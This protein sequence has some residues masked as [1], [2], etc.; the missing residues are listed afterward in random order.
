M[1]TK[2]KQ[3]KHEPPKLAIVPPGGFP[4]PPRPSQAAVLVQRREAAKQAVKLIRE[5]QELLGKAGAT[6]RHALMLGREHK[7]PGVPIFPAED[8][9]G[10]PC[11][12]PWPEAQVLSEA[13]EDRNVRW[14]R[15][16][17][18]EMQGLKYTLYKFLRE[19]KGS[20]KP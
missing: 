11:P 20:S 13:E 10:R 4:P 19:T 15:R 2:K 3:A 1:A 16:L 12:E 7:L 17:G 18:G 5:A 6:Y 9:D 14:D 8:V